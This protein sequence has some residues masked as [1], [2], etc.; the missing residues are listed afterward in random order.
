VLTLKDSICIVTTNHYDKLDPAFVRDGRF[1]VKIKLDKCDHCQIIEIYTVLKAEEINEEILKR[2][3]NI[4]LP[5]Y[6]HIPGQKI[7]I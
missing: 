6:C 2:F 1:D 5:S 7:Y 3:M 4:H